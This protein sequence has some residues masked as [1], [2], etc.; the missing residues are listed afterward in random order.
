MK[1]LSMFFVQMKKKLLTILSFVLVVLAGCNN[2]SIT[3]IDANSWTSK[4]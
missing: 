3:E 1:N 4:A 2:S